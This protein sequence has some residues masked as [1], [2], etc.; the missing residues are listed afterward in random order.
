MTTDALRT[1]DTGRVPAPVQR[2]PAGG[3]F[4]RTPGRRPR[5]RPRR[6]WLAFLLPF[7]LA[8]ALF[9]LV[10]IGYAVYQ[11]LLR[12][13]RV[14]GVFGTTHTVFAGTSQYSGILHDRAFLSSIGRV[15]VFGAVQI[16]VMVVLSLLL[17]LLLDSKVPLFT[18]WFRLAFFVPYAVPGVI[19]AIMWGSFY[20]PTLS[21]LGDL[22]IHTDFLS[23]RFVLWSIANVGIWAY[24]G[25]N[26]LVMYAA[27][28]AVPR[29]IYEAAAI[30]GAGALAVAWRIKLPMLRPAIVLTVVFSII[31]CLQLFTEPQVFRAVTSHISSTYTPNLAAYS[32]ASSDN[33]HAAAAMSVSLALVTFVLSFGF[34]RMTRRRFQW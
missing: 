25:Y 24:A 23:G 26:M 28:Q 18:R 2:V 32:A 10:P 6:P 11:S 27:L 13:E 12:V 8:F 19:A 17:A 7:T 22:G 30:D 29:E 20:A 14:G 3:A 9:Y 4:R 33:Y 15:A 16:P 21:P 5:R 34:L 31:G 1:P